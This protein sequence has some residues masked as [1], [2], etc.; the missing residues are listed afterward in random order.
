MLLHMKDLKYLLA[1]LLPLSA[2]LA[3]GLQGPWAWATVVLSFGIIPVLEIWTPQSTEN[4]PQQ[5]LTIIQ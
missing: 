1:Y 5:G 4:V 3:L 2:I